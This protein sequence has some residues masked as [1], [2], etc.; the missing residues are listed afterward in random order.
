M[1]EDQFRQQLQEKGYGEAKIREFEPNQDKEMHTHDL[2]A[3]A[4]V[5]RGEFILALESESTS[6]APGEWC[7]LIAGTVHT[8]R[9]GPDGATVLLAYK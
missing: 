1:T 3:M 5:M 8:E 2:S 7:E 9:T 6:Y 4:L